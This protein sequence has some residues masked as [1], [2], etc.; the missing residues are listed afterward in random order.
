MRVTISDKLKIL[1]CRNADEVQKIKVQLAKTVLMC[2]NERHV[3]QK[4]LSERTGIPQADISRLESAEANP[5]LDKIC[6]IANAFDMNVKLTF[7][8]K[9]VVEY[10]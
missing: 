3:S 1:K 2:R 6:R 9:I 10:V 7:E 4:Q 5:T 8:P